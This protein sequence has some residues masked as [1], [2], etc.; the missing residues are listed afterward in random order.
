MLQFTV[1]DWMNDLVVFVD[2]D[3]TVSDALALMRRRYINSLIVRKTDTNPEYGILTSTDISD[4][5]IAQEQN[6]S[7][8]KVRD[9]MSS[10]I[11]SVNH[12]VI[13]RDCAKLMNE[14]DI[15]HLPVVDDTGNIVGMISSTDFLVAAEAMGRAPGERIE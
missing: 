5:I 8:V 13:L 2:P 4:K 14:H 6:P 7:Q 9:L 3:A 10:P 15:H 11:I 12:Q 1:R